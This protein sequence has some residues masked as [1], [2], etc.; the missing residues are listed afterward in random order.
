MH[1]HR[2]ST[3]SRVAP[4]SSTYIAQLRSAFCVQK[5]NVQ[6]TRPCNIVLQLLLVRLSS[7]PVRVDVP[8]PSGLSLG[9]ASRPLEQ[10]ITPD[11]KW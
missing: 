5:A 3:S 9:F 4:G 1:L 10:I 8:R 11:T 7:S 2:H 6:Y